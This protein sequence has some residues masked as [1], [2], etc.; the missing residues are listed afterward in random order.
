MR[1]QYC[2]RQTDKG[3]L[4]WDVRR[5]IEISRDFPIIN[6][7]L[8]EIK[9]LDEN[10]WYD[11]PQN[12]PTCR[13]IA[14][15]AKL[16]QETDLKYPII[17]CSEGRTMDGMHRVCK[18]LMLGNKSIGAKKLIEMPEPDYIDVSAEDL[19]YD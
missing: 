10:F 17:M 7:P 16:I 18:A 6:I 1:R 13:S 19:P 15:H 9:E 3:C 12:V 4:I 2:F 8:T 14:N 11:N 5:L